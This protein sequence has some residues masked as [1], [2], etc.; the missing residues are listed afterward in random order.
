MTKTSFSYGKQDRLRKRR[1]YLEVYAKGDKVRTQ[2]FFL[3][4][5]RNELGRNRLGLTVSRKIGKTVFRNK[6]KRQLR[7]IFRLHCKGNVPTYDLVV[8]ATRAAVRAHYRLLERELS[9]AA[10]CHGRK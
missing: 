8:N 3:Y 1:E 10:G 6:L 9:R 5:L 7:E 2:Y 4:R